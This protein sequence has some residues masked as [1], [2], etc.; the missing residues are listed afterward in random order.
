MPVHPRNLADLAPGDYYRTMPM[1]PGCA[2]VGDFDSL[3]SEPC[4]YAHRHIYRQDEPCTG[5][6]LIGYAVHGWEDRP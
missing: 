4:Y 2:L 5:W 3:E 1:H 6:T